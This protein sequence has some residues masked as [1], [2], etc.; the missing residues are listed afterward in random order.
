MA[1]MITFKGPDEAGGKRSS[2]LITFAAGGDQAVDAIDDIVTKLMGDIVE[3]RSEFVQDN[4]L[5]AKAD[6]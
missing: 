6:V 2:T 1:T 3:R 5:E 4:S